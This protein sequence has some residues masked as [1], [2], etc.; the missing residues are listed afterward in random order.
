MP[1]ESW[2]TSAVWLVTTSRN[3]FSP[4]E[5]AQSTN[6]AKSASVPRCGSDRGEVEA[7]VA[8]VRR[9]RRLHPVLLRDRGDPDRG[10]A[11]V[12]HPAQPGL[13]VGAASGQALRGHRRGTSRR[14]SGRSPCRDARAGHAALV[15][16]PGR[17]S[18]TGRASRSRSAGRRSTAWSA[19]WPARRAVLPLGGFGDGALRA[20]GRADERGCRDQAAGTARSAPSEAP[21]RSPRR[22]SAGGRRRSR[23]SRPRRSAGGH[24]AGNV[25][26]KFGRSATMLSASTVCLLLALARSRASRCPR[27]K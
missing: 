21:H 9:A 27:V 23:P 4:S 11:E 12:L 14:P 5:C 13:R 6:A 15:V 22:R 25:A 26:T 1:P 24:A 16:R 8:V 19:A 18:R 17:R 2:T 20:D 10:E 7:P 3:T